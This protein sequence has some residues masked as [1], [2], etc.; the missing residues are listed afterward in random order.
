ML[1]KILA[2]VA[3][4][5]IVSTWLQDRRADRADV[6]VLDWKDSLRV[7]DSTWNARHSLRMSQM[8]ATLA[9]MT[10]DIDAANARADAHATAAQQLR[11]ERA[12]LVVQPSIPGTV[13]TVGDT[14][15]T[16]RLSVQLCEQEAEAWK[17]RGDTLQR[18]A[19]FLNQ[20]IGSLR[21]DVFDWRQAWQMDR[22]LLTRAQGLITDLQRGC[23]LVKFGPLRATCPKARDV[24]LWSIAGTLAATQNTAQ[25]RYT[26]LGL[27]AVS[28]V[29]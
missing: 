21:S 6:A 2:V 29:W 7:S 1:A 11:R 13:P 12:G 18:T 14:L 8:D 26:A 23:Y 24:M 5:A 16:C 17:Q 27:V 3:A 15:K 19:E 20:Q 25:A 9:Q 28:F 4:L 10:T 22:R